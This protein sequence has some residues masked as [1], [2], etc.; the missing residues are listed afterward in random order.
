MSSDLESPPVPQLFFVTTNVYYWFMLHAHQG[1]QFWVQPWPKNPSYD[2][3]IQINFDVSYTHFCRL[4]F[5]PG[6]YCDTHVV[7]KWISVKMIWIVF[8][9]CAHRRSAQ[10]CASVT[11]RQTSSETVTVP[12][13][14][15]PRDSRNLSHSFLPSTPSYLQCPFGSPRTR[16]HTYVG[17]VIGILSQP[18]AAMSRILKYAF[19]QGPPLLQYALEAWDQ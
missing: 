16:Q 19:L 2:L 11:S 7:R 15:P 6:S 14:G 9:Q 12:G 17:Q 3:T 1:Y 18:L 13:N 4:Y 5:L 8:L 10:G